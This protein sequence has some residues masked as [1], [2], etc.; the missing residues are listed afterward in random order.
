LMSFTR[1]PTGFTLRIELMEGS[2]SVIVLYPHL[3]LYYKG[4]DRREESQFLFAPGTNERDEKKDNVPI[5]L[6]CFLYYFTL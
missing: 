2:G 1:N 3:I 4:R 6:G 5:F